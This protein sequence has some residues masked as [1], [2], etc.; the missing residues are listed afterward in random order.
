MAGCVR[1]RKAHA[2]PGRLLVDSD[3]EIDE[4]GGATGERE[5]QL[6]TGEIEIVDGT[7]STARKPLNEIDDDIDDD[8]EPIL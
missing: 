3:E 8:K 4:D 6:D 1:G 5:V 2:E 7:G